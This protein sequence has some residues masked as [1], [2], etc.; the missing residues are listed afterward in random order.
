MTTFDDAVVQ[1]VTRHM[2]E[3]HPE[4]SVL[5]VRAFADAAATSARMVGLDATSGTWL[6]EVEDTT[7]A[8][9]V[10]WPIPVKE[11][12]D[13]RKAVVILYEQACERLGVEPRGH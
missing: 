12:A 7:T 8:V 13:L 4:D 6:A 3:D 1:A 10:Q 11:R 2:N 5:I 9:E